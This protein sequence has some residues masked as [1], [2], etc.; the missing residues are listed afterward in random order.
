MD[1][2]NVIYSKGNINLIFQHWT[3]EVMK[4]EIENNWEA[5]SWLTKGDYFYRI[6]IVFTALYQETQ[7]LTM[8]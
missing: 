4:T 2:E 5:H 8:S 7:Q 6:N 3:S 1:E